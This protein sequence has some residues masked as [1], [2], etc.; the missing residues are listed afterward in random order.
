M[1]SKLG[2]VILDYNSMRVL[3]DSSPLTMNVKQKNK[4]QAFILAQGNTS[5]RTT[6]YLP[7]FM[8]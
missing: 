7:L 3:V 5:N 2:V 6:F 8:N 4:Q 1:C